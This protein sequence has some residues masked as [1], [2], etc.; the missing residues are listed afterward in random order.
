MSFNNTLLNGYVSCNPACINEGVCYNSIC[1]CADPWGGKFWDEELDTAQRVTT[2][3]LILIIIGGLVLGFITPLFL[4][5]CWDT[6]CTKKPKAPEEK[7]DVWP[8]ED[9]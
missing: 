4:K 8:P 5:L 6:F 9:K 3:V 7:G 1:Y 2:I